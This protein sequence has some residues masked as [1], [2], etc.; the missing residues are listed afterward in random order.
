[1]PEERDCGRP[2]RVSL[3]PFTPL[4][5]S[6]LVELLSSAP[7]ILLVE[8]APTV[9]LLDAADADATVPP[10]PPELARHAQALARASDASGVSGLLL[11]E[12]DGSRAKLVVT[13]SEQLD[14][15]AD[16]GT[17][18]LAAIHRAAAGAGRAGVA[19]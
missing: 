8:D 16:G 11:M 1:M 3:G 19:A 15:A 14:F 9:L 7:G 12:A 4:L 5:R 2:I 13:A 18:L 6:M 17:A 10:A